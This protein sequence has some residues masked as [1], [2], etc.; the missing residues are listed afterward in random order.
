MHRKNWEE[1]FLS[2]EKNTS[3]FKRDLAIG[4]NALSL[5]DAIDGLINNQKLWSEHFVFDYNQIKIVA[6]SFQYNFLFQRFYS[7]FY[8]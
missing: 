2:Y 5:A 4:T 3:K 8:F 6:Y 1:L 7:Q